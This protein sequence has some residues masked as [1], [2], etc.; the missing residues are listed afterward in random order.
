ML[1]IA[2]VHW[3]KIN[4]INFSHYEI[5]TNILKIWTIS[6]KLWSMVNTGSIILMQLLIISSL[7]SVSWY[8]SYREASIAI[9]IVLWGECIVAALMWLFLWLTDIVLLLFTEISIFFRD[10]VVSQ[11][12]DELGLQMA[13]E[14]S[15]TCMF[16]KNFQLFWDF[17][18]EISFIES[19]F[20]PCLSY[21]ILLYWTTSSY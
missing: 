5:F 7:K 20:C 1:I 16:I 10:A 14:L 8:V 17:F 6:N 18:G 13:D 21:W 4:G 9:H 11:V 2:S 3:R 12:L 19:K 15:G